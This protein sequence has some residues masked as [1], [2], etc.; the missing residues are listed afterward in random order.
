MGSI[1]Q[2]YVC[3]VLLVLEEIGFRVSCRKGSSE[4]AGGEKMVWGHGS[5]GMLLQGL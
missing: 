1:H 2:W 4:A 5:L 3:T